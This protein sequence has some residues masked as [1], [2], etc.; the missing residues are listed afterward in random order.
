M[1]SNLQPARGEG[2]ITGERFARLESTVLQLQAAVDSI[3]RRTDALELWRS[4]V[5]TPVTEPR[6]GQS[7]PTQAMD[8]SPAVLQRD[9]YDLIGILSLVGRL[10][11]ALAGGFFL[12]AMTEAGVLT[13]PLGIAMAFAYGLVWIFLADWTGRRRIVPSAVAHS[14]AAAMVTFPLLVEATTRF[15]VL[16]GASSALGL[17]ILTAG[18]LLVAW[19]QRL[20]GVA[21]VTVMAALPTGLVLMAKTGVIAPFA[22]FLIALGVTTLWLAYT[23][24]WTAICWPAA[25]IADVVVVGVTL[26]ALS[27]EHLDTYRLAL[28]LQWLL[29][30][31]YFV[32]VAVR[33]LVRG[34]NVA[35]FEVAQ[36]AAALVISFVGTGVLVRASGM[37]PAAIG[38]IS[39]AF[40]GACYFATFKFIEGRQDLA[41]N[42]YFY[43]TL[44]LV[45]VLAGFTLII[46]GQWL[47]AI[48]AIFAVVATGMWSRGG[49]LYLLLHGAAYVLAAA[50]ASRMLSYG[51]WAMAASPV[52]PWSPPGA[53]IAVTFVA[54]A[55]SA[56][57]AAVRSDRDDGP[58]AG[59]LRLVIIAVLVWVTCSGL[60]GALAP[61][62]AGWVDGS[63]DL[64]ALATVR[65]GVLAAAAILIAWV[66]RH[67]RFH[68]WAWLVYPLLVVIG[69]KMVL[70][71]F[72]YSRPATLFIALALYGAALIIAPRLRRGS[73]KAR[74]NPGMAQARGG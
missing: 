34:R 35:F 20:H 65:T 33:T 13:P 30:A 44:A 17:V 24:G 49:R 38:V 31:A 57:L 22:C 48:F 55:L 37:L 25:L 9:P 28:M 10:F 4:P 3:Q 2:G 59:G 61:V 16:N 70:Q 62:A 73:E 43:S 7:T 67:A 23:R 74:D 15:N 52:G 63:V 5:A 72:N 71:D 36:V 39:L 51:V 60:I 42:L 45:L 58:V 50:F 8:P 11:L 19:R 56:W 69:L 46:P 66:G 53:M 32:S 18:M 54:V 26:R 21:W 40:G 41:R 6:S 27:P 14:L 47:A 64:G 12:R 1:H 68:E 29:L